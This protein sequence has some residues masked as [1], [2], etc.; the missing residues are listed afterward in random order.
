MKQITQ[1]A[2]TRYA[3]ATAEQYAPAAAV[4][5]KYVSLLKSD[6]FQSDLAFATN[7]IKSDAVAFRHRIGKSSA[8]SALNKFARAS[9]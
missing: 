8:I 2:N 4:I 7:K 9:K 5:D 3:N 6:K 1:E